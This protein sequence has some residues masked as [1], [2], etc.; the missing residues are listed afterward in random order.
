MEINE[1]LAELIGCFMGD[2][3]A[4][5]SKNCHYLI[6]FTGHEDLDKS[7]YVDRICLIVKKYFNAKYYLYKVKGKQAIRINFFSKALYNFLLGILNLNQGKK[8]HIIE[9]PEFILKNTIF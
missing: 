7:Y 3:T 4:H 1:E 5:H 2:G 8:S 9:I 6:Q